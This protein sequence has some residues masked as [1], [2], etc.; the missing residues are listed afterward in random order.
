MGLLDWLTDGIGSAMG[1]GGGSGSTPM[2]NATNSYQSPGSAPL[3]PDEM[4]Q[5]A[6]PAPP[7]PPAPATPPVNPATSDTGAPPAAAAPPPPAPTPMPMPMP[8]PAGAPG[9]VAAPAPAM[10]QPTGAPAGPPPTSPAP[11]SSPMPNPDSGP[12]APPVPTPQSPLNRSLGFAA[13]DPRY[14]TTRQI[15]AGLGGGL[16]AA[17]NSKGKSAGQAFASG[18]GGAFTGQVTQADKQYDQRL[19]S[20]QLAVQ[21]KSA[22]NRSEYD[23]N[24]AKYLIGKDAAGKTGGKASAWNKPDSQ[25]YLDAKRSVAMDPDV[26]AQRQI[27][28]K[29]RGSHIADEQAKL[30]TLVQQKEAQTFG[31]MNL[32]PQTVAAMNGNPPGTLKNP[33]TVTSKNDFDLYV[34][35]GQAYK[36]PAD[37]K[38]YIRNPDKAAKPEDDKEAP[39]GTA[40]GSTPV[41]P[42]GPAPGTVAPEAEPAAPGAAAPAALEPE[43]GETP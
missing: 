34:K 25:K 38:I 17:G 2:V 10:P 37:G 13:N 20:L 40:E 5:P 19:K 41:Q 22:D 33:H 16:T 26:V 35:P 30:T 21:A 29:A 8:R 7:A 1:G 9:P 43:V 6:T 14:D 23:K 12:A 4:P 28:A 32:S 36:N 15:L 42:P 31:V 24:Y 11:A 27:V 39:A 18:A 3:S